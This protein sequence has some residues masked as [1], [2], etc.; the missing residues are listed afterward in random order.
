M[1]ITFSSAFLT[2]S[3]WDSG[4]EFVV[5]LTPYAEEKMTT[6]SKEIGKKASQAKDM[7]TKILNK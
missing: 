6:V 5:K 7:T 2:A 4:R 1:I 3:L